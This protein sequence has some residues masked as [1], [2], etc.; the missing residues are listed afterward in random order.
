MRKSKQTFEEILAAEKAVDAR[1]QSRKQGFAK[2][3]ER[4][5]GMAR[6]QNGQIIY[7]HALPPTHL[8]DNEFWTHPNV[9]EGAFLLNHELYDVEDF[10]RALRWV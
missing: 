6:L 8:E 1:K 4:D 3:G 9:P 10:R 2:M 7:W 5:A